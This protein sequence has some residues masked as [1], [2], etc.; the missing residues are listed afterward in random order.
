MHVMSTIRVLALRSWCAL[1][2]VATVVVGSACGACDVPAAPP[3]AGPGADAGTAPPAD[4]GVDPPAAACGAAPGGGSA[5][6]TAPVLQT[7][8]ADQWHEG[9]L[10][11]PAAADLDGDG[12]IEVIGARS[13]RVLAWHLD[14]TVV[15]SH[16]VDGRC[17][18]SPVVA[19]LRPD[20]PGLEVAQAS[21]DAIFAWRADGAVLPGFPYHWR[22]ELRS[23]AAGDI[24][25]DGALEL[26]SVTTNGLSGGGQYDIVIAVNGDGSVVTGFPPNTTG[27][28]GC[29]DACYVTNGYDQNVA[30]GDVDDDG[31]ADVFATHDNAY[32]SLHHGDGVAFDCAAQFVGRTKFMGV[33]ALHDVAEAAQG[34]A[35]DEDTALQAHHTNT[36]PA[37]A[38]LDGDGTAELVYLASV[39][40]AAQTNRELG[41]ALWAV[42][43][44]GTR[45]AGWQT[46][47]RFPDY[48]SGLW[49]YGATNIVAITNQV[50]VAD[51]D[52]ARP[53][54]EVVFAGF[55][56]RIHGV[57]AAQGS[58]F[59]TT[60]TTSDQTG[61]AGVA[62][63]D[64]SGD[65]V[66]ELVVASYSTVDGGAELFVLD[67]AGAIV[68]RAALPGRGA[69]AVPTIAN[70]DDDD[71]LE[72]VVALKDSDEGQ[73]QVYEVPGSAANCLL[74]PT[75]RGNLHRD[76]RVP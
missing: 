17:W 15:W 58:L 66:P 63:A 21:G 50:S 32:N 31:V 36:A 44:D 74:W 33:R 7:T 70:V 68:H 64:L 37:I 2:L 59:D 20:L 51:L 47:L 6:V 69:M 18:S 11:S 42:H 22:N 9:W 67:H 14:G 30:L 43:H 54:L 16:D 24:D 13:G 39:Q 65:G 29:D 41:V 3:D 60:Y 4:G 49:D 1:S 23:L 72:I 46:P 34:Y 52:A 55:D 61:T 48:L 19:D 76:G 8:L 28:S 73:V 10:A 75:G 56:G 5:V 62:V 53:G 27:T 38:D 25:G 71:A 57:D 40:N 45:A 35:D 12:T 26:V